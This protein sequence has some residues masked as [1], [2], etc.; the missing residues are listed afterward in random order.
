MLEARV[1]AR[2]PAVSVVVATHNRSLR[3]RQLLAGLRAQTLP[4]DAF[5]VIVV[6]DGSSDAT[7][8]GPHGRGSLRRPA[9]LHP[10]A[11]RARRPR[12]GPQ[13][14]L[15]ARTRAVRGLHRR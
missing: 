14:R 12:R 11:G 13:P 15:E 8:E 4:L 9:A 10:A 1:T 6:D 7:Q 3:L 5:E 2:P